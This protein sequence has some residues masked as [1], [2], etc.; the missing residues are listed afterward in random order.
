MSRHVRTISAQ[1]TGRTA[2]DPEAPVP[3]TNGVKSLIHQR[4]TAGRAFG[5][6]QHQRS[7]PPRGVRS[8]ER[9]RLHADPTVFAQLSSALASS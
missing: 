8:E 7:L 6:L 2:A 3:R 9:V 1:A 4:A 5:R